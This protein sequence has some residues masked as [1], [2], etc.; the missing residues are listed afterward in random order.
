LIHDF[1]AGL[2]RGPVARRELS[3][4]TGR[5]GVLVQANAAGQAR[6]T[7]TFYTG[8]GKASSVNVGPN[9]GFPA[10]LSATPRALMNTSI[11]YDYRFHLIDWGVGKEVWAIPDPGSARVPGSLPPVA[12]AGDYLLLGGLEYVKGGERQEPV[13]SLYSLDPKAEKVVAHWLPEPL[14]QPSGDGGRFL[15]L[16]RR[17]FLVA[18]KEFAEVSVGDIVAKKKGWR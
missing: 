9:A 8:T 5:A 12:V 1:P 16:G 17:L 14:Y 13:R 15:Q 11:G 18:D 10:W 4:W 6:N 2:G 3:S 7:F